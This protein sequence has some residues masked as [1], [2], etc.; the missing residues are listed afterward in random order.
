DVAIE[1]KSTDNIE[2]RHLKGIKAFRED[3]PQSR[4]MVVSLDPFDRRTEK[5][6]EITNIHKFLK[7]L[8][9]GEIV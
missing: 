7:M 9:G 8:W 5:G 2:T 6:I 3:F 1:I 4:L